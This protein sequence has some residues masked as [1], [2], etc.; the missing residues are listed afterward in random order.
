MIITDVQKEIEIENSSLLNEMRESRENANAV[1]IKFIEHYREFTDFV[2]CFYEG[3]DGKYYNQ[4]IKKIIGDKIIPLKVGDKFN[5]LQL[6][7]KI[8]NDETYNYV[9]K[10]FFV[11]RDMDEIPK[12]RDGDLYITPCY[13]IENLYVNKI[14][15][16]NIL[17]SEFSLNKIDS[18]YKKCIDLFDNLYEQFCNEMVEFNALVFIR[19]RKKLGNG[20][21]SLSDIKITKMFSIDFGGITRKESYITVINDLKEKLDVKDDELDDGINKIH[22]KKDYSNQF[23]G[24]N[25]LDF[26]V[27]LIH[28]LKEANKNKCFFE[29]SHTS[30]NITI[31][32]NRLSELSQYAITPDCLVKFIQNH[33]R[34]I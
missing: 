24:K 22:E 23:R 10:M 15:F 14:T 26:F 13:S 29:K 21:V 27:A 2:F 17:E 11:D 6:W 9:S 12:D 31:T 28:L 20:N 7:R 33:K 18:D 3:E 30:V 5:T 19:N 25:Q 1:F 4:R 34:V 32:N 16:A 8:N